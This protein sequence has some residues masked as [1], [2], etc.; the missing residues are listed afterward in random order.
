MKKKAVF[1]DRDGVLNREREDYTFRIEDF[2]I[3]Q[4]VI[5]ALNLL[6]TNEFIL[7]VISNQ[8]GIGKKIYSK[9]DT[10]ILHSYL[11]QKLEESGI[12]LKEI[13]Y[14]THHP[15]TGSCICRKPDSLLIEKAIARFNIN[16]KSSYFI[17]DKERDIIAGKK[18]GLKGILIDS[19]SSL[20]VA[21]KKI[22]SG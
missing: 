18:A 10:E 5:P 16:T 15:E 9:E 8:S 7:I 12:L 3:L 22:I 13:Y 6:I 20:L 14:C 1:L 19:N 17:G 11:E 21:V 2:D 4:D